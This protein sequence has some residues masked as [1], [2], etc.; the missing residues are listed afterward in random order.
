MIQ[1]VP[2]AALVGLEACAITVEV[3]IRRGTPMIQ[4]VG[5]AP[6]AV[7][8]CRERFRA[9]A[10]QL[11]LHVP[12]LRI[13]VNLAPADVRKDGAAYDLPISVG[14]LAASGQLPRARSLR[15]AMVGE[16]GLDGTVRGVRG[17]LP[18]ALHC[19]SRPG[20]AGLI[21]PFDNLGETLPIE[22]FPVFGA[23]TLAGVL[24][25]LRGQG[26]LPRT[27]DTACASRGATRGRST[28][29]PGPDDTP[30]LAEVR[31]QEGV[32][33]ALEVA[34][35]GGHNILLRGTPG[36]GKTMLARRLPT[37]LPELTLSEAVE[38]TVIRSVAGQL[39]P[40]EG[41]FLRSPFRAPHHSISE[42]GL[43]G[44][45]NPPRPGEV[46][47]AHHGVLFLDELPEFRA[48][49]LEALRQPLEEGSISLVRARAAVRY[50]ARFMLVAAMNPCPCGLLTDG[51]GRCTCDPARVRGYL[52]RIS[53]PLLDRIDMHVDVPGIRWR[54]LRE[55]RSGPE[56]SGVRL[57]VRE[58][59]D[60]ARRRLPGWPGGGAM[61]SRLSPRMLREHCSLDTEGESVISAAAE[62]LCLSARACH[63]ALRVARTIADLAGSERVL[64]EHV[65]EAV[66]YR[67][68]DR[69]S[70]GNGS[71]DHAVNP[72]PAAEV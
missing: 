10:A 15:Y 9:A 3:S 55:E 50:P 1:T 52:S 47:L 22:D 65:A 18:I 13:T 19:R 37:I 4:I 35:A 56:S 49:C 64:S 61:N 36:S 54:E 67:A 32:I 30:D 53:G 24:Q 62:R 29:P 42:A 60:R 8:A 51:T 45:G 28:L 21:V 59:R 26:D 46:S 71:A 31:G 39:P 27:T 25:F 41:L 63:R 14:I 66:Q 72:R 70:W 38:A 6:A 2:T 43:I 7:A 16:L 12:G 5:L 58:A 23:R 17:S 68:L 57:R 40:G 33:R 69:R 11:D 34:A 48:R 44:G 20:L